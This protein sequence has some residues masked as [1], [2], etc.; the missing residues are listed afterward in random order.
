MPLAAQRVQTFGAAY[1]VFD[2]T[3]PK[4]VVIDPVLIKKIMVRDFTH[5][6][7]RTSTR[8]SH[9]VEQKMMVVMQG[10]DWA[11]WRK[12]M[13][14]AFS[15]QKLKS[16]EQ[17][18]Q[19]SVDNM[20][21]E[22]GKEAKEGEADVD[23]QSICVNFAL[24]AIA[25]TGLGIDMN[26]H[27]K[28]E[29]II[30]SLKKY[31]MTSPLRLMLCFMLPKWFKT[32][33]KYTMFNKQGLHAAISYITAVI[34]QRRTNS[35]YE[36]NSDFTSILMSATK[37]GKALPEDEIT[38]NIMDLFLAGFDSIALL[39]SAVTFSLAQHPQVQQRLYEEVMAVT[40]GDPNRVDMDSVKNMKY[41]DA[42]L[43]ET[44]RLYP[45]ATYTER[46]VSKAY[47][48]NG[49][50]LPVGLDILIPIYLLHHDEKY[51]PEAESFDPDRFMPDRIGLIDHFT[52]LPFGEGPRVCPGKRFSLL[53]V[54][55]ALSRLLIF[56][57]I[58][59]SDQSPNSI[60]VSETVD[61][62]LMATE[63]YVRFCRRKDILKVNQTK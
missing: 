27:Q 54:K 7:D 23:I 38:A 20:I 2:G 47:E 49:I 16:M 52:F 43:N 22:I 6:T 63:F 1:G 60:D 34:R 28:S 14:P 57:E 37:D 33:I 40:A 41:M 15:P 5:F 46:K 45:P 51:H 25:R 39:L 53:Q 18:M 32:L 21:A 11:T 59:K 35:D 31:I 26:L 24:E 42:V 48:M 44:L 17:M 58:V 13:T 56:F 61:E 19:R 29:P 8:F 36:H 12:I 10:S 30:D 9:P 62:L 4:L 55:I 50:T 3:T